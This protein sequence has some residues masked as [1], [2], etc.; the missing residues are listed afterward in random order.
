MYMKVPANTEAQVTVDG[1]V[2]VLNPLDPSVPG[3]KITKE[4]SGTG[5]QVLVNASVQ[6]LETSGNE[7]AVMSVKIQP[8][9][10]EYASAIIKITFTGLASKQAIHVEG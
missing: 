4:R 1:E 7:T 5:Y 6:A 8:S 10:E 3:L 2:P 9:N